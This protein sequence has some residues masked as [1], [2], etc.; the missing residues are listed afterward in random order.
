MRRAAAAFA[1][2]LSFAAAA[3]AV[4]ADGAQLFNLQCKMCH[5]GTIMGPSL[6]GVAG[7]PVASKP[8]FAYSPALKGKGGTWTDASLDAFL[9]APAQF[10]PGTKMLV[11]VPSEESRAAIIDYLKT[12]K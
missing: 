6:N 3:P 5:T 1:A 12:L 8:G 2:F 11:A 10:A 7:G 4:A 9:K